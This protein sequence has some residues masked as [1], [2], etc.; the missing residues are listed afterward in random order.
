MD[1]RWYVQPTPHKGFR[2]FWFFYGP[3]ILFWTFMGLCIA[4]STG[5]M[6]LA[7][8]VGGRP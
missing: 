2:R 8:L 5:I 4:I 7:C 1:T 6:F 3:S